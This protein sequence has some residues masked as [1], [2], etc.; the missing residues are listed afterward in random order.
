MPT[1]I[2]GSTGINQTTFTATT[3]NSSSG[4]IN[5]T[6]GATTPSTGAFTTLSATGNATVG[7]SLST[8]WGTSWNTVTG[9]PSGATIATAFGEIDTYVGV[10]RNNSATRSGT[11]AG[12]E[13]SGTSVSLNHVS[14]GVL[15]SQAVL[16]STGLAV[17]GALST[18]SYI[19]ALAGAGLRAYRA[20]GATYGEITHGA[21]GTGLIYNDANGD[22]HVWRLSG[23]D[24]LTLNGS[25]NLG[26]GVTPSAWGNAFKALQVGT[27]GALSYNTSTFRISNGWYYDSTGTP[28]YIQTSGSYVLSYQLDATGGHQW[29]TAP[30]GTAGNPIT[31]TQ[32]M[33]LDA[34]GNLLVGSIVAAGTSGGGI[35]ALGLNSQITYRASGA[36]AGKFRFT[37]ADTS[38]AFLV[39]NN[40]N[41]GMYMSDGATVWTANSDERLKTDLI[42]ITDALTKVASLRT[43]TGRYKTDEVGVSRSFL[44]AQDVIKV[45]PEA[46]ST[47]KLPNDD[48]EYLG[49]GYSDLIPLA[50]AA[51][52]EQQAQIESL[53]AR[54]SAAGL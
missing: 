44:I 15:D 16:S 22:G 39:Y 33:T 53:T 7:G 10:T 26:L 35:A 24:S 45:L 54:L 28:K 21:A 29:Y 9:G 1:T 36:T 20:D 41:V 27:T 19:S 11:G 42:P 30:G 37:A 23:T 2:S 5:A 49:V 32:A 8:G 47:H 46:V 4:A 43:V 3:L 6:I 38:N 31:F 50:L 17:T 13:I 40:S 52:K 18:S 25:G 48:T 12:I 14:A 34:S 51:I